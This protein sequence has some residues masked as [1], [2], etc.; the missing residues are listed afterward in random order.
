MQAAA[1][2][3]LGIAASVA[4][5]IL[6]DQVTVRVC[7]EYFTLGHPPIFSPRNPTLLAFGWGIVS[8]WWVG[9]GL[10][11]LLAVAA[12][13]GTRPKRTAASLVRPLAIILA[14]T[15]AAALAAGVLGWTLAFRGTVVLV[16]PL[17]QRIPPDGHVPFLADLWA[18]L[19]SCLVGGLLG[20]ALAIR[21]W[22][23]RGRGAAGTPRPD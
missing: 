8:T 23:Q 19:A 4:Y 16:G 18:H 21:V 14:G 20:I 10:G 7:L 2:V 12:R 1:I 11:T 17:A 13:A 5:G 6:H 15:G 9:A 3:L 22:R